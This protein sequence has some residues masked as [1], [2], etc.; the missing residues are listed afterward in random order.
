MEDI[1]SSCEIGLSLQLWNRLLTSV[2]TLCKIYSESFQSHLHFRRCAWSSL[3][4]RGKLFANSSI[5]LSIYRTISFNISFVVYMKIK[6]HF[7]IAFD[8]RFIDHTKVDEFAHVWKGVK[9]SHSWNEQIH[10][11]FIRSSNNMLEIE[12][13]MLLDPFFVHHNR[14]M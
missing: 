1:S 10:I 9:E 11:P 7:Y 5:A 3:M 6:Y 12:I 13:Y 4:D 2:Y 8:I 14:P